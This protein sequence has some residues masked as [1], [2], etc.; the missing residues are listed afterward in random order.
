MK[1]EYPE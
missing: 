1:F